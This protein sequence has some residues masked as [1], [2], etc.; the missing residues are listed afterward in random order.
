MIPFLIMTIYECRSKLGA[1]L[2]FFCSFVTRTTT[3][4]WK[5][6]GASLFSI[7]VLQCCYSVRCI[8]Q[9]HLHCVSELVKV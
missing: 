9:Q 8:F 7:F 4:Q 6:W 2:L 5:A 3:P 1:H